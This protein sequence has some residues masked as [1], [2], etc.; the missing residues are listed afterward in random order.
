M[1]KFKK[2]DQVKYEDETYEFIPGSLKGIVHLRK[3]CDDVFVNEDF[4]EPA[5]QYKIGDQVRI[6]KNVGSCKGGVYP[7]NIYSKKKAVI[8]KMESG[9]FNLDIDKGV[10][11]WFDNM[12]EKVKSKSIKVKKE[13][14]KNKRKL[15][16]KEINKNP[17]FKKCFE[18]VTI[19][20]N[21]WSDSKIINYKLNRKNDI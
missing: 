6:V 5:L 14:I 9:Y 16:I 17:E 10:W 12:F 20:I 11:N 7:M 19:E 1:R 18:N 2:G 3:G 13:V 8:T 4:F 21:S 15:I